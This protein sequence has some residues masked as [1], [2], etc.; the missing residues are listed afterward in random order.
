MIQAA[1]EPP[2]G[3]T[4]P[5]RRVGLHI[6]FKED[7]QRAEQ[8]WTPDGGSFRAQDLLKEAGVLP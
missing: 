7:L 1:Q 5:P 8:C 6:P 4:F 3:P 2:A